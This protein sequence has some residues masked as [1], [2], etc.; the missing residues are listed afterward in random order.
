MDFLKNISDGSLDDIDFPEPKILIEHVEIKN[1]WHDYMNAVEKNDDENPMAHDNIETHSMKN[2]NVKMKPKPSENK[3]MKNLKLNTQSK[4]EINDTLNE[5]DGNGKETSESLLDLF[6]RLEMLKKKKRGI[7]P[8][9]KNTKLLGNSNA[10]VALKQNSSKNDEIKDEPLGVDSRQEIENLKESNEEDFDINIESDSDY[11]PESDSDY[12]PTKTVVKK[13]KKR[14]TKAGSNYMKN[15]NIVKDN[16]GKQKVK[17]KKGRPKIV[18]PDLKIEIKRLLPF[19]ERNSDKDSKQRFVCSLCNKKYIEKE[20]ILRHLNNYHQNEIIS[21]ITKP[22]YRPKTQ[23]ESYVCK[24]EA[25]NDIYGPRWGRHFDLWCKQCTDMARLS[26]L[27]RKKNKQPQKQKQKPHQLCPEC[28]L[29]VQDLKH[30]LKRRHGEK[31]ICMYW[32]KDLN[33]KESLKG[34]I[35]KV[36]EKLPCELCGYLSAKS[37]M[38]RHFESKHTPNDQKKYQCV[39]CGKGFVAKEHLKDHANIH[40]GEKP[41]KCIYCSMSFASKGTHG[42]HQRTHLGHRRKY[43]KTKQSI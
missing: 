2:N 4:N 22:D 37:R 6:E 43:S 19:I 36:H 42:M 16:D 1:E 34:H 33:S 38:N 27:K 39:V 9:T 40:T 30:H 28:G 3:E 14:A 13:R 10:E 18:R 32:K 15:D 31:Q 41:Y 26:I 12:S 35:E 20:I 24:D 5:K 8:K 29:S 25:C 23:M 11:S 21:T 7:K 17:G